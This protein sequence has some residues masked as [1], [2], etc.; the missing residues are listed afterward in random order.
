MRNTSCNKD[1]N[2]PLTCSVFMEHRLM[3]QFASYFSVCVLS[4]LII[5]PAVTSHAICNC[6]FVQGKISASE[7]QV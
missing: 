5:Y 3:S 7:E 2:K 4:V 1:A 6:Q